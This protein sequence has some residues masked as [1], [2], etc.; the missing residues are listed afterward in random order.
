MR[1]EKSESSRKNKD[2]AQ[3]SC[4]CFARVENHCGVLKEM[5][6]KKG[7]CSF[8]KS[9]EQYAEEQLIYP[10]QNDISK[11]RFRYGR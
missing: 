4:D 11:R 5:L 1:H 9:K 6:C 2:V 10:N 3:L 7:K 8:Y